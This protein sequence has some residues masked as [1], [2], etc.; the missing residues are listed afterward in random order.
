MQQ[1]PPV[2]MANTSSPERRFCQDYN[3]SAGGKGAASSCSLRKKGDVRGSSP[4]TPR[5]K[6]QLVFEAVCELHFPHLSRGSP[7]MKLLST[8]RCA[9]CPLAWVLAVSSAGDAPLLPSSTQSPLV[10][11]RSQLKYVSSL[12]SLPTS[13]DTSSHHCGSPRIWS[14]HEYSIAHSLRGPDGTPCKLDT[15]GPILQMKTLGFRAAKYLAKILS[16]QRRQWKIYPRPSHSGEKETWWGGTG[17]GESHGR[18]FS[19]C[20]LPSARPGCGGPRTRRLPTF[21]ACQSRGSPSWRLG[22]LCSSTQGGGHNAPQ[23]E[24]AVVRT[25]TP[26]VPS[27]VD[28]AGLAASAP[29]PPSTYLPLPASPSA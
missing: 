4:T 20:R 7:T 15:V 21:T 9:V 12:E 8:P 14:N 3:L 2:T 27:Q 16:R 6:F 23:P 26:S 11:R 1:D 22:L 29:S 13:Q 28:R 25:P 19:S 24:A 18:D 5:M 10:Y 17:W